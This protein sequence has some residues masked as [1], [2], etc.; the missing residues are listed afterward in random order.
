M[1]YKMNRG[2]QQVLFNYLPGKTF[3]FRRISAIARVSGIRGEP[4]TNL[5]A[6]VLL[7][8]VAED[9]RAWQADLR[10]ILR[11]DV[12][13][14]ATRFIFIDPREVQSELFPRVFWCQNRACGR[15]FDYSRSD[16]LPP[17]RCRACGTD[18][19]VQLRFVKIHR[20]GALE[21]L[22]P[23]RCQGC[24]NSNQ[25]ALDTRGSER[26]S[27]FRWICRQC[28]ARA[29]LY[30][31]H[32]NQCQWPPGQ[33]AANKDPRNMDIELHRSG[34]TFYAHTAVLLNVPHREME[35]FFN[36]AEWSFIAAAKFLGIPEVAGRRFADFAPSVATGSG[37]SD[38]GLSGADL[39]DLFR[40]QLAGELTSEQFVAAMQVLRERRQQERQ[41]TSP[42]GILE[43]VVSR[44]GVPRAT[45]QQAGQELLESVLPS[46][47]GRPVE[48]FA[49]TASA[50]PA[51]LARRI[52]LT[53]V[54]LVADYP[55]VT[56]TY[57]FSRAEYSPN[58]CRLNPFPPDP[59][60][61][62]RI[63][64][65]VDQV[66]ADAL[67]LGLHPERVCEWLTR[68]GFAPTLPN[69]SDSSNALRAY[70]VQLFDNLSLRE[71]LGVDQPQARMV[72]GLLHTLSHFAVRQSALLCGLDRTS[73]AE[74]L[75]PRSLTVAIYCN[76]RF[77]ATIGALTALFEQ[78]LSE[79]LNAIRDARRCVY[80][81][82][83]RDREGNCHACTHL[84]ETSCR[85]FNLNLS[86][87]FLFGGEDAQLGRIE[88][89][90][91]DSSL[92]LGS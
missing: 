5:N 32:C 73:L 62:G 31:G 11:D 52:G 12:L 16:A 6:A 44:T 84:A 74:Y 45:W 33:G 19:I 87:S 77:G 59:N 61:G 26:I 69:G 68:N 78:S 4:K 88:V 67:L 38:P 9:A 18:G 85:F 50:A 51:A 39:D 58:E 55:I 34:R 81:P 57:G 60:Q 90:Y 46:E 75:L 47:T 3:D 20:C 80:D 76:H 82:V 23:P 24:H 27:N 48:L 7:R 17:N 86:R 36:L 72:F 66:Q 21:P 40:R 2:K 30:A 14:D 41:A 63:P 22:A 89:G 1:G 43:S 42:S 54:A 56:A 49:T 25:M 8:K 13:G 29:A 35:G 15:I 79:W 91:F 28:G 65:F 10:P 53:R 64:I 83:C 92:D 71:T 37:G 70:F